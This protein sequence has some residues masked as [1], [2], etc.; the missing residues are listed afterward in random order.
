MT[1]I[2]YEKLIERAE[3]RIFESKE[4]SEKNK[5][6]I[7]RYL[8]SY[9]VSKAR[10]SIFLVQIRPFIENFPDI[11]NVNRDEL[12]V[13]FY[14]L[15]RKYAEATVAT[16]VSVICGLM[17]WLGD[18]ELPKEFSDFKGKSKKMK[19]KLNPEQMTTW[20][21][22]VD[23]ARFTMSPQLQL[24]CTAQ[25]DAG[26]RPGEFI[27][28]N[29]KHVTLIDGF[30]VFHVPDGKTGPRSVVMYR[31]TE[32]IKKWL[33]AHP[34][35]KPDDPL[36]INEHHFRR[37]GEVKRAKYPAIA[38]QV[39][40]LGKLA[41]FKKPMDF[42]SLRHSSCTLDKKDNIPADLAAERHGHSMKY[43]LEVYG[44]LDVSDTVHRFRQHFNE[45]RGSSVTLPQTP[46]PQSPEE[47]KVQQQVMQQQIQKLQQQLASM[48]PHQG[49]EPLVVGTNTIPISSDNHRETVPYLN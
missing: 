16:Y 20:E 27:L 10:I 32:Y 1:I 35:K 41:N 9:D 14:D 44:R 28:L 12:N 43:Y 11:T 18:G 5:Q 13:W 19:R 24:Q 25:V 39:R 7:K 40:K 31:A 30:Y 8:F 47:A 21:E 17:R 36:W 46:S 38:Q 15:K 45:H 23:L 33:D 42:Y 6:I 3:R 37:T 26:F 2:S 22:A 48:S 49:K 4:I 34:T 29:Y